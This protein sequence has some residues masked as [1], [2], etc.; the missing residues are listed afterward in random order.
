MNLK[1]WI[2]KTL[3]NKNGKINPWSG[4]QSYWY[5]NGFEKQ[6]QELFKSTN[7]LPDNYS[8]I[9]RLVCILNN[10]KKIP[11][12]S[13]CNK[14][15]NYFAKYKNFAKTCS[16]SCAAHDPEYI[17]KK[18]NTNLKKYGEKYF[19]QTKEFTIKTIKTN[20]EKYGTNYPLQNKTIYEKTKQTNL[21]KYGVENPFQNKEIKN[22]IHNSTI[23][24][25]LLKYGTEYHMQRNIPKEIYKKLTNKEWLNEQHHI[26]KKPLYQIAKELKISPSSLPTY[27]KKLGLT[28]QYDWSHSQQDKEIFSF[29][30]SLNFKPLMNDR[31]ILN[32][33]E[34]DIF[35][36][37]KNLG[38]E[39]HG[40]YWHS[41]NHHETIEEKNEHLNKLNL[42]KEKEIQLLQI[43]G[44][45]WED[46]IKK[47]IW[48][49]IISNKLGKNN[50]I[51]ARKCISQRISAKI[52]N[53]FLNKNHL[54]GETKQA[55]FHLGLFIHEELVSVMSF[56][57]SRFNKKY[58]VE[59]L[60]YASKLNT[61][62]LGGASKLMSHFI[63]L[64]P[65]KSIISYADRRYATGKV[66]EYLGF[67]LS[68]ITPPN[69]WY[70]KK[71]KLESRIKYQKYKLESI[72]KTFDKNKTEAQN[73]FDNGYRR[74]WDCGNYVFVKLP[75]S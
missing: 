49:S 72:F 61:N 44:N 52:A 23:K 34:I 18:E 26:L 16:L 48:K 63:K 33:K 41:F 69:Y 30:E 70:V 10:I 67:K 1:N 75:Q 45:E 54:Q 38:I 35:I 42:C 37:E 28:Q 57:K 19:T 3:I 22:K 73:M 43:F 50:K 25:S 2:K 32:G 27:L 13:V 60:R 62:I 29:V 24:N 17:S 51:F 36:P 4:K 11:S 53:N 65:N 71:D 20:Q 66:Y 56:G 55:S 31:K 47:N 12:C 5:K 68:H 46:T 7:F 14:P 21:K 6:F 8:I 9:E 74:I 39:H 15:V 59:L 64:F 58:D 40:L